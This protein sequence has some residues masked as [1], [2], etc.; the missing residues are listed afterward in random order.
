MSK[1]KFLILSG[2]DVERLFINISNITHIVPQPTETAIYVIGDKNP[3]LVEETMEELE[4]LLPEMIQIS[5]IS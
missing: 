3:I 1:N 2:V 5:D 4:S